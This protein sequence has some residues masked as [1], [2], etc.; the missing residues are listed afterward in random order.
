MTGKELKESLKLGKRVY[1]T[2]IVS[3]SPKWMDVISQLNLDFVFIDTEHIPIDRHQLS[4][5]CHAYSGK[6]AVPIVRIPSPDPFQASMVLDGGAKG[7][8]TP[9]IETA[10]EV[11][12]LS[13]AVQMKPVKGMRLAA[14]LDGQKVP[15]REL[16]DYLKT[17]NEDNSLIV[18]VESLPAIENLNEILAVPGL[19]A[20]LIG[21]H[22]L[23][24]S[25]GIP[26]KYDH[27]KFL[28]AVEAI[29]T[30]ARKANI[31]AG[32][33]ATFVDGTEKEK[34]WAEMG[35]NLIVHGG[36]INYFAQVMGK[37]IAALRK[38]L[39]DGRNES[40]HEINI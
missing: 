21:P 17:G 11:Q 37:D 18:N 33:H 8:V 28:R 19:D 36:D 1:G 5:M 30:S 14:F 7:V 15:E 26:E 27:P 3:T 4:W 6:G 10:R 35:A 32:I 22:D 34:E 39:G 29:L 23:S 24:C 31:G 9:Y 38:V 2:L 12:L 20:I 13:G 25:L 40:A 16:A